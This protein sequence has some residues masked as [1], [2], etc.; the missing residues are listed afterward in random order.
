MGLRLSALDD[1]A[2]YDAWIL[3]RI[4]DEQVAQ[5]WGYYMFRL[6]RAVFVT[7]QHLSEEG[8]FIF[9]WMVENYV[10]SALMLLRRELDRQ[11][12]TENLLN[13]LLD[14]I[15]H[16]LVV[17]R[18]PYLTRWGPDQPVHRWHANRT[19]DAIEVSSDH[20][21]VNVVDLR[22]A[23]DQD[24]AEAIEH[25]PT[26]LQIQACDVIAKYY[27]LLTQRGFGASAAD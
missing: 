11:D 16:P 5:A 14:M 7:N 21:W 20:V 19:F 13:L 17:N 26:A 8:G 25:G 9:R 12:G 15:E 2:R 1:D 10:D 24:Q 22:L 23:G 18:W 6:L 3:K 4:Y 27:A